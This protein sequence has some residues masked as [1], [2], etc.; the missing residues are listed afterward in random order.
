MCVY[1]K[2]TYIYMNNL[3]FFLNLSQSTST[4]P[5]FSFWNMVLKI[6]FIFSWIA[7]NLLFF[8]NE[9]HTKCFFNQRFQVIVPHY[10]CAI[11]VFKSYYNN[12]FEL[13]CG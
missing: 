11:E 3:Q 10:Q 7:E 6:Q 12:A 4:F 1:T 2:R 8:N 9:I 5:F 13:E